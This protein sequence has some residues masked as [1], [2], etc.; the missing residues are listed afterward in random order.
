M[1]DLDD[2]FQK[3]VH[4]TNP[5]FLGEVENDTSC[6]QTSQVARGSLCQGSGSFSN[7]LRSTKMTSNRRSVIFGTMTSPKETSLASLVCSDS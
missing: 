1:Q 5:C 3:Q 4:A 2:I 6:T 7:N